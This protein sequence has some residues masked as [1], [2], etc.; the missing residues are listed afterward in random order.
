MRTSWIFL[1]IVFVVVMVVY[2]KE[3]PAPIALP[4]IEC[5]FPGHISDL[6]AHCDIAAVRLGGKKGVVRPV[7]RHD[8][9]TE[10][11]PELC[12]E[13]M[14]WT[15]A[16]VPGNHPILEGECETSWIEPQSCSLP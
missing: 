2:P 4:I 13:T 16:V 3:S 14:A 10:P 7:T 6:R 5:E 1:S 15:C 12:I 9:P 11:L 8:W